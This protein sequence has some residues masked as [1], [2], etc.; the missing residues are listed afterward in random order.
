MARVVAEPVRAW[1]GEEGDYSMGLVGKTCERVTSSRRYLLRYFSVQILTERVTLKSVT[2]YKSK[3]E[4]K[5]FM[6]TKTKLNLFCRD[7]KK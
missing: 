1:A 6:R 5:I 7:K 4:S 2:K 3:I